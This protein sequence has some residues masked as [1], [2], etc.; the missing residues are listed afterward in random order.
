MVISHT[1]PA[2]VARWS[3]T[4]QDRWNGA[5]YYSKEIVENIIPLVNTDRNWITINI[6]EAGGCDHSIVFIHNNL[7]PELYDWLKDFHDLIL[8]CGVPETCA[9]MA[10]LGTPIY[11][12]LSVDVEDVS[13]Y[14]CQ[15]TQDVAFIGRRPKRRGITFPENTHIIEGLPRSELLKRMAAYEKVYAVG[16]TAVEAKILGCEILPYDPRFP[17]PER[18]QILDNKDAAVILQKLLDEVD[19]DLQS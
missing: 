15:K 9:K 12:P 16:R 3:T 8:V 6:P 14:Y 19:Y 7:H 5:Y 13:Q 17:D 10:H 1:H 18:W 4:G 11:L 2:Y